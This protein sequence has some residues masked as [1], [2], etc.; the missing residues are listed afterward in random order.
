MGGRIAP[1]DLLLETRGPIVGQS[2]FCPVDRII[3]VV[4]RAYGELSV[5][6]RYSIAR[7]I[8]RL[9]HVQGRPAGQTVA[10]FFPLLCVGKESSP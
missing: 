8:G 2:S 10:G 7:L 1:E 3:C 4:P 5:R 9:T 6:D